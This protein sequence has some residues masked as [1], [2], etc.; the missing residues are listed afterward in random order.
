M[1]KGGLYQRDIMLTHC[2][3]WYVC[4]DCVFDANEEW[5]SRIADSPLPKY[6]DTVLITLY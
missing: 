3:H 6:E 2:V 4:K 5:E 1:N